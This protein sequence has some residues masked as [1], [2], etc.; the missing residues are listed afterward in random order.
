MEL[1]QYV[2]ELLASGV[3]P[4]RIKLHFAA[5]KF[6]FEKTLGRPELVSFLSWPTRFAFFGAGAVGVTGEGSAAIAAPPRN[7]TSRRAR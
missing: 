5:L 4:S 3:G 6:L 7:R 2:E 1:R